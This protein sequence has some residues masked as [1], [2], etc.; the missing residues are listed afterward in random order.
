MRQKGAGVYTEAR[1]ER[2]EKM[3]TLRAL[4]PSDADRMLEWMHDADMQNNFQKTMN[5]KTREDVLF[6]INNSKTE[7]EDGNSVHFA[8][9]N[10]S[11][12][13]LGTISLKNYSARDR[14]AEFAIGLCKAAQGKGIGKAATKKVLQM[15]FKEWGLKRVY[16]NVLKHNERAIQLYEHC[17]FKYEGKFEKHLYINGVYQDLL[18]YGI[19]EEDCK[20]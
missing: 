19:L 4:N 6:F 20:W 8:I 1:K 5:N 17:G 12:E 15:A 9:S 11:N 18:W 13:Y 14:N 10:E 3:I 7:I 16:L 2:M